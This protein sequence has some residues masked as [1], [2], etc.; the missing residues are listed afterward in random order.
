MTRDII[1]ARACLLVQKTRG[2]KIK[3]E[4]ITDAT[5]LNEDL[6]IDSLGLL[7][8]VFEIEQEFRITFDEED[9]GNLVVFGDVLSLIEK[10]RERQRPPI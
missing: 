10:K 9:A 6:L 4:E 8:L 3:P 5:R 1:K 2:E 7:E